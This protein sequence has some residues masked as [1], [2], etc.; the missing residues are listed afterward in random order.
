MCLDILHVPTL[1]AAVV[2]LVLSLVVVVFLP[3]YKT[4]SLLIL[5]SILAWVKMLEGKVL[6]VRYH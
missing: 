2:V 4:I 6:I 1:S 5:V 3:R